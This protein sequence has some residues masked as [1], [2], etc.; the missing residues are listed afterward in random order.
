MDLT[1]VSDVDVALYFGNNCGTFYKHYA[2]KGLLLALIS[3]SLYIQMLMDMVFFGHL[4][5]KLS[6]PLSIQTQL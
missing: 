5:V 1:T 3:K 2:L 6:V 4:N